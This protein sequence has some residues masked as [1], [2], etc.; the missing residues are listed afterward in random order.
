MA[1]NMGYCRFQNTLGD[2]HDCYERMDDDLS[3][4]ETAARMRLIEVC[5]DIVENYAP[6][7]DEHK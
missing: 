1:G 5:M 6:S 4:E 3:D 7:E 2:L